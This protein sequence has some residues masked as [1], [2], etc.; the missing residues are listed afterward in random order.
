MRALSSSSCRC[1]RRAPR[2]RRARVWGACGIGAGLTGARRGLFVAVAAAIL[3]VSL[4]HAAHADAATHQYIDL[5]PR[6]FANPIK[7]FYLGVYD[8]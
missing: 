4:P 7:I 2:A 5:H 6:S 8:F 3:V 1:C